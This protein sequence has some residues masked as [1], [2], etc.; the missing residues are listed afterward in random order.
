MII[1]Q[2][3][4]TKEIEKATNNKLTLGKLLWSI[5][6]GDGLTQSS[7]AKTLGMSNSYLRAIEHD[8]KLINPELARNYAKIL[9]YSEKQFIR[10]A[11]Q[12]LLDK[13]GINFEVEIKENAIIKFK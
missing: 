12:A 3:K 1:K 4:L 5:R 8:H 13:A 2:Q 6:T 9:G 7:F 11:L 10:L